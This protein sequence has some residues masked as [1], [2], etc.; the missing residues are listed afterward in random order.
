MPDASEEEQVKAIRKRLSSFSPSRC[1]CIY[2]VG[3]CPSLDQNRQFVEALSSHL[4]HI[5]GCSSHGTRSG[6]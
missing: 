3:L 6:M 1:T 2:G 4:K 5:N